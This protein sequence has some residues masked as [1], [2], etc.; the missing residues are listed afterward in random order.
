MTALSN[1]SG[2]KFDEFLRKLRSSHGML[3]AS[4]TGLPQPRRQKVTCGNQR[5]RYANVGARF[6]RRIQSTATSATPKAYSTREINQMQSKSQVANRG[7][8]A[9]LNGR[10]SVDSLL[11]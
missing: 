2:L 11:P 7:Q 8:L 5:R 3:Q 10:V 6:A 9:E 1:V 4:I